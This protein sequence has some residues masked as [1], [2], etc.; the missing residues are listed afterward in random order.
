MPAEVF[1]ETG[2]RG[3]MSYFVKPLKGQAMR[4]FREE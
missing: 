3:A 1:M 2:E 4:V